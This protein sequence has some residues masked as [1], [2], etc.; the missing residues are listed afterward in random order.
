[1]WE[2]KGVGSIL[3]HLAIISLSVWPTEASPTTTTTTTTPSSTTSPD[4]TWDDSDLGSRPVLIAHRGSSG[5]YPE[6]TAMAYRAAAEQG[7]NPTGLF[8]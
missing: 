8:F 5:M 6:H 4:W 1:M 7:R 3:A 2:E